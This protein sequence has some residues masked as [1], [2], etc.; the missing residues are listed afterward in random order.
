MPKVPPSSDNAEVNGEGVGASFDFGSAERYALAQG[1]QMLGQGM[2]IYAS[3]NEI[4]Q[5]AFNYEMQAEAAKTDAKA[6]F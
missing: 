2:D 4:D 5:R 3:A 6:R 1:L